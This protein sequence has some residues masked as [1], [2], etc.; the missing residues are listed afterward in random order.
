MQSHR[1]STETAIFTGL[2]VTSTAQLFALTAAEP[3]LAVW[4]LCPGAAFTI[5]LL[6]G[7]DSRIEQMQTWFRKHPARIVCVPAGLW[8]IYVIYAAGMGILTSYAMLVMAVYLVLPF[9]G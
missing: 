3:W 8:A 1:L 6:L 7:S 9:A 4:M 5:M 2:L